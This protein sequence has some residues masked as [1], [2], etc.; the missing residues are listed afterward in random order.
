MKTPMIA[1]AALLALSGAALADEDCNVPMERWQP[2]EAVM[3]LGRDRGWTVQRVKVDD[4][5]Y[6][7][8]GLDAEGHA[9]KVKVDPGTLDLVEMNIRYRK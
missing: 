3:Q 6:E 5:C 4:G 1:A 2:R 8:R 7:I 9:I